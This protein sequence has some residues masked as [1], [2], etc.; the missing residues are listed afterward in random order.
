MRR[1]IWLLLI[2]LGL[3][4]AAPKA[5][6]AGLTFSP[7]EPPTPQQ[8]PPGYSIESLPALLPEGEHLG[9]IAELIANM[10][11]RSTVSAVAFSPDGRSLA[12][13]SWDNT[14][15]LWDVASGKELR[16]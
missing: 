9:D 2:L 7:P 5:P 3:V 6:L 12:S 1:L 15:R 8:A 11:R 13:G 14:I 4:A 16:R 10:S